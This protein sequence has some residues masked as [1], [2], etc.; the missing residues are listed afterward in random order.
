MKKSFRTPNYEWLVENYFSD[1]SRN[2]TLRKGDELLLQG[3]F[4]D[5][6]YLVKKGLLIGYGE[7]NN[8]HRY[9]IFRANPRMFIGV[10]SYFSK[11]F[12]S[13][14]TVVAEK[15]SELAYIDQSQKVVSGSKVGSLAEEFMPM[16]VTEL[17]YRQK[18]MQDMA[19][20]K[21]LTIKHLMQSEKMA[22]LGQMA[23]GIAHE[24]NNAI[25]V[26]K[27]NSEWI[28]EQ[29]LKLWKEFRPEEYLL[30]KQGVK[31]GRN[32]SNMQI[33][34]RSRELSKLYSLKDVAA[35]KLAQMDF[36]PEDLDLLSKKT[37]KNVHELFTFWEMGSTIHDM[38]TATTH[39]THVVNSIKS[40]GAE[41]STRQLNVNINDTIAEAL[42][43]LH[44]NLKQITVK[45][46]LQTIPII[47]ANKGEFV[48]V[49]S[50]ILK[51][52]Y[53]SLITSN[54]QRPVIWIFSELM[55]NSIIIKIQDN[56]PGIPKKIIS[57]IFEPKFTTKISGTS[58]GL[59]LG[60]AIVQRIILSYSGKITV[61][62]EKGKT[63]FLIKIPAGEKNA[64]T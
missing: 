5:R 3:Q 18:W 36:T 34:K 13:I 39:S 54:I 51:N 6:L 33:R 43:L 15:N 30:F 61:S 42:S 28:K 60:L 40:M 24:L 1:E 59:G 21:E 2:V 57:K 52:A 50:N 17:L 45:T 20:E 46:N 22:S 56:G 14:A 53:D 9:E 27:R 44:N 64:E 4:N 32:L 8:G 19:I 12:S 47:E 37:R 41:R 55:E 25:A 26:L 23:A 49:W 35:E 58:I 11:T 7:D 10:Y 48:Q 31:R 38:L 16:V 29:L 62:S 63:I